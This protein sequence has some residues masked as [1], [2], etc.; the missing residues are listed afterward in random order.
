MSSSLASELIFGGKS[1][2]VNGSA[3]SMILLTNSI[4][5]K[6]LGVL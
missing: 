6:N 4:A 3:F 1:E 5:F 2:S